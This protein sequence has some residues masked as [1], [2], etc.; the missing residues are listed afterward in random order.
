MSWGDDRIDC[1]MR[2]ENGSL[3]LFGGAHWKDRTLHRIERVERRG[4]HRFDFP[5]GDFETRRVNFTFR[6]VPEEHI[7]PY[8]QLSERAREDV[9]GYIRTLAQ[10]SVFYARELASLAD[11]INPLSGPGTLE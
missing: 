8:A 3:Q 5:V 4:G 11:Q 6:Y 9:A 7:V 1:F 2:M 10:S